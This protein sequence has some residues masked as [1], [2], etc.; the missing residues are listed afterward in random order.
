MIKLNYLYYYLYYYLVYITIIFWITIIVSFLIF[1]FLHKIFNFWVLIKYK[2]FNLFIYIK[3]IYLILLPI[4]LFGSIL[5]ILLYNLFYIN[6]ICF[7][8]KYV[9]VITIYRQSNFTLYRQIFDWVLY[10]RFWLDV[11]CNGIE[12]PLAVAGPIIFFYDILYWSFARLTVS[13]VFI[14]MWLYQRIVGFFYY[15][16]GLEEIGLVIARSPYY[17]LGMWYY[18]PHIPPIW[19]ISL[20]ETYINE[21]LMP[22]IIYIIKTFFNL[23]IKTYFVIY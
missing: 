9:Y 16:S 4:G 5:F 23:Y 8:P 2:N 6:N 3:E 7:Y 11:I 13:D 18:S 19:L 22:Q 14:S 10:I 1:I 21:I 17:G 12:L 20:R 15:A